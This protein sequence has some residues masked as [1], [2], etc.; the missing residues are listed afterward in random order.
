MMSQG[1]QPGP[2]GQGDPEACTPQWNQDRK[3]RGGIPTGADFPHEAAAR[4]D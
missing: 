1:V 2:M 3:Y 4:L